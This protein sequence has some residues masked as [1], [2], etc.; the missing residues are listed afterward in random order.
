MKRICRAAI[1]LSLA[2]L[3]HGCGGKA[4][5]EEGRVRL[6]NATRDYSALDL[7]QSSTRIIASTAAY[8]SSD[9]AGLG[10]ESYTFYVKN[11]GSSSTA[12]TLTGSVE[13]EV[14][15]AVV[16]YVTGG[17]MATAYISESEDSPSSGIAKLRI[18]NAASS[19]VGSVDVYLRSSACSGLASSDTAL[20]TSI[21]GLQDT[22]SGVTAASYHVCVT[23]AGDKSDLRLDIPALTLASQQIATL[24]LTNTSGGVLLNGLLL[25]QQG[26]LTTY[27][28]T[29][30]RMRLAADAASSG[31]VSAAANGTTLG[32]SYSSPT[33]GSYKLVEAGELALT[34]SIN[35]AAVAATG[36]SAS[37]GTDVTLLV[38]GSVSTPAITLLT[39]DNTP[40]T[41]SSKPVKI[42]LV[43]GLNGIGGA[44]MLTVDGDVVA[45][46][47]DFGTA[48]SPVNVPASAAAAALDITYAGTSLWSASSQTLT[49]GKVYTM[50]LLGDASGAPKG[51]LRAD[52]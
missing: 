32:T 52:H 34:V 4:D 50:F 41:S 5:T 36:F 22:Y 12:A 6:V 14:H 40:S 29:S 7:Y 38:A 48:S 43:N 30:V 45:D 44:A 18:F 25:N 24:I 17:T 26:S 3:L 20:A 2:T 39:D 49:S 10:A 9:Y 13:K 46:S 8:S 35:G 37:A 42:R 15:Y 19:E 27:A 1:L 23:T 51:I 21:S 47:V 16:A 33:V 28:N 11:G 31:V